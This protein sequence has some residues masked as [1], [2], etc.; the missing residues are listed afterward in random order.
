MQRLIGAQAT[1]QIV[2]VRSPSVQM[3][4]MTFAKDIGPELRE[5]ARTSVADWCD[6]AGVGRRWH[7]QA[8][9]QSVQKT[10]KGTLAQVA[11]ENNLAI[12]LSQAI[13]VTT[14]P[15]IVNMVR[16]IVAEQF[17]AAT[18]AANRAAA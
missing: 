16:D 7:S 14:G 15:M 6:V 9:V 10:V 3:P 12:A 1:T 17:S 11:R 8:T 18:P 4:R 5:G 13:S 2:P